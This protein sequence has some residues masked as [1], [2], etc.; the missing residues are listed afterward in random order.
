MR[1]LRRRGQRGERAA[2]FDAWWRDRGRHQVSA[3]WSEP[4]AY[5]WVKRYW[6]VN[7]GGLRDAIAWEAE[8]PA[9]DCHESGLALLEEVARNPTPWSEQLVTLRAVQS[10]TI[11]DLDSDLDLVRNLGEYE[12]ADEPPQPVRVPTL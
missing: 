12:D 9:W 6:R 3:D 10:L 4:L 2:T 1:R 8:C 11:L 7:R 5:R